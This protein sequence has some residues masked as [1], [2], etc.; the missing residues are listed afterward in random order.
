MRAGARR[1]LRRARGWLAPAL[2]DLDDRAVES[3]GGCRFR[4]LPLLLERVDLGVA[5]DQ[6][7]RGTG[8][9]VQDRLLPDGR[10][11]GLTGLRAEDGELARSGLALHEVDLGRTLERH[12]LQHWRV[13]DMHLRRLR[14]ARD[15]RV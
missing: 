4:D 1:C 8:L 5:R 13:V 10:V 11:A 12:R 6:N 2:A 14:L 9:P 15:I 3:N 7:G